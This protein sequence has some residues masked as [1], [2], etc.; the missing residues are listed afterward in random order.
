MSNKY[1]H[2]IQR[3]CRLGHDDSRQVVAGETLTHDGELEMCKSGLHASTNIMDALCYA[4]GPVI[5][6]VELRGRVVEGD[7]KAVASERYCRWMLTADQSEQVLMHFARWCALRVVH[8]WD[9]PRVVIDYLLTGDESIREAAWKA[10]WAATGAAA[11]VAAR[12][13]TWAATEEAARE[14]AREAAGEA[15]G[16]AAR[17]AARKT[18][19]V[20]ARK[21]ARKA[22]SHKLAELAT[23]M[24]ET[25]TMPTTQMPNM[26]D[27]K[28]VFMEDS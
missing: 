27:G 18:A 16:V 6:C 17:K 15:A 5:C 14:A 12:V 9:A 8:L 13:A 1:W 26:E 3:D 22:Q 2:F 23:I 24:H 7:D 20:A 28:F 19:G 11:R 21:A 4:P 25:G 10:T